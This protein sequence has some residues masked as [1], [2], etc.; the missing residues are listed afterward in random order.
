MRK[1]YRKFAVIDSH[2]N[3]LP[4]QSFLDLLGFGVPLFTAVERAVRRRGSSRDTNRHHCHSRDS[5]RRRHRFH[6]VYRAPFD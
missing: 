2:A 6:K 3:H 5:E 4:L 1:E